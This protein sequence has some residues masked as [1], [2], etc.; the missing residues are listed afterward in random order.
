MSQILGIIEPSATSDGSPRLESFGESHNYG[1]WLLSHGVTDIEVRF[2]GSMSGGSHETSSVWETADERCIVPAARRLAEAGAEVIAW[3]CTC[4]SFI[5][6]VA[7]SRAQAS[8]LNEI[9]G[10]PATS[11]S[12]AIISAI[13]MLGAASVDVLSPYPE[14][15]TDAFVRFLQENGTKVGAKLALGC[16]D[17]TASMRLDLFIEAKKFLAAT[18]AK[19][20][21]IVVPDTAVQSFAAIPRIET[22]ARRPII[23]ANQATLWHCMTLL[24][25]RLRIPKGGQLFEH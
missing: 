2:E 23:T 8:M 25:R 4:G 16:E 11:T 6:G 7:W 12:I 20:E 22:M 3:A 13:E 21:V 18:N 9:T 14:A 19:A 15:V 24:G 17:D 1:S 10:R 5:G